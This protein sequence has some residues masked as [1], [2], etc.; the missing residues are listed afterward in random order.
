MFRTNANRKDVGFIQRSNKV[1]IDNEEC[2]SHVFISKRK[3]GFDPHAFDV[4]KEF[5]KL[6]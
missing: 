3:K 4:T 1:L 5:P 2:I 6:P